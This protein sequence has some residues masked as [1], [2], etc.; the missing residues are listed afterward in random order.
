[1]DL[2]RI[3]RVAD[4]DA[5]RMKSYRVLA[6]LVGVFKE[7]DGSFRAMEVGCKHQNADLTLGYIRGDMAICTRHGWEYNLKTGECTNGMEGRLR[8]YHCEVRE[9]SIYISALPLDG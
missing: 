7:A 5:T 2:V 8:P 3:A 1:M 9:D 6:R 4:F